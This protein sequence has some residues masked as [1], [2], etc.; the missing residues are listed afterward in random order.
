[1]ASTRAASAPVNNQF[2]D[3]HPYGAI[4]PDPSVEAKIYNAAAVTEFDG[5]IAVVLRSMDSHGISRLRLAHQQPDNI[6]TVDPGHVLAPQYSWDNHGVEDP[7]IVQIDGRYFMTYVAFDGDCARV[8]M[9]M[10]TDLKNWGER[11]LI[12]SHWRSGLPQEGGRNWS[13][14]AAMFPQQIGNKYWLLFGDT[15]IWSA[16][17]LDL[18]TW[19]VISEPVLKPRPRLWDGGYIEMGPPPIFTKDGWLVIYHGINR[20]DDVP[21]DPRIYRL[22]AALLDLND[23]CHVLW[24]RRNFFLEPVGA[25]KYGHMDIAAGGLEASLSLTDRQIV[26]LVNAGQQAQAIFCCGAVPLPHT[27]GDKALLVWGASDQN[28]CTG[29]LDINNLLAA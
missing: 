24:R 17:S 19:H 4:V 12:L 9:A 15:Y 10:S 28:T 18:E 11:R 2:V 20:L 23:P 13:K 5:R 21:G 14:A 22:G 1:M 6:W 29:V 27:G 26:D 7:R 16:W 25:E 8:A 3:R